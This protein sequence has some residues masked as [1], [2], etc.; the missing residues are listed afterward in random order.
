M[1]AVEG[2][3]FRDGIVVNE[4]RYPA[5]RPND[6][7]SHATF[8]SPALLIRSDKGQGKGCGGP[9]FQLW[10]PDA[11]FGMLFVGGNH[12]EIAVIIQIQ[13]AHAVVLTIGGAQRMARQKILVQALLRFTEGQEL[14]LIAVFVNGV[15]NQFHNL[16]AANPAMGMKDQIHRPLLD[17]GRIESSFP[18]RDCRGIIGTVQMLRVPI[19]GHQA[20]EFPTK[21]SHDVRVGI[22]FDEGGES[23]ERDVF[24]KSLPPSAI[25]NQLARQRSIVR[26]DDV[27]HRRVDSEKLAGGISLVEKLGIEARAWAVHRIAT[28]H[29]KGHRFVTR[30]AIHQ[31]NTTVICFRG[32]CKIFLGQARARMRQRVRLQRESLFEPGLELRLLRVNGNRHNAHGSAAIDLLEPLQNRAQK[33]FPPVG[34]RHVVYGED[35]HRFNAGFTDPLRRREPRKFAPDIKRIAF[36]ERGQAIGVERG[37]GKIPR[38]RRMNPA[39]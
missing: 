17:N 7:K 25:E 21:F 9:I 18:V 28:G 5:I 13:Q 30:N 35:Y 29:P 32:G 26:G 16:L 20:R 39:Q 14:H 34:L 4:H 36:V 8:L 23:R 38:S 1:G 37:G 3:G 12:I 27:H 24:A 15:I 11:C 10:V 31:F 19:T 33:S 22:I 6:A 2:P